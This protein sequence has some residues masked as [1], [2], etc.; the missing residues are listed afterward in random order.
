M[1]QAAE[2][3]QAAQ[4]AQAEGDENHQ[5]SSSISDAKTVWSLPLDLSVKV[6][7]VLVILNARKLY[8]LDSYDAYNRYYHMLSPYFDISDDMIIGFMKIIRK[9]TKLTE[10]AFSN[11]NLDY[12]FFD[13]PIINYGNEFCQATVTDPSTYRFVQDA[14][15]VYNNRLDRI[16]GND[17]SFVIF[18]A[19]E[20]ICSLFSQKALDVIDDKDMKALMLQLETFNSAL[21]LVD[22]TYDIRLWITPMFT[23]A[24]Y[25]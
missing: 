16:P 22:N 21:R 2:A 5:T 23:T 20:Y 17:V 14:D 18:H 13:R 15:H 10:S 12:V 3:A 25:R 11:S 6:N 8:F 1:G 7:C 9:G 4:A 19:N 24:A